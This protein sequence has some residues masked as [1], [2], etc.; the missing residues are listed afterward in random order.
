MLL[1]VVFHRPLLQAIG[2]RAAIHFAA[3]EN[4]KLDCRVEGTIFSGV[5]VRN[6]HA[7]ATGPSAVQAA[8]VE[9]VRVDFS[10]WTLLRSG[11][12]SFLK[13]VEVRNATIVV[14]PKKAPPQIDELEKDQKFTIPAFFPD[15]L[16][17][18]DINLRVISTPRDLLVEHLTLELNPAGPGELRIAKVQIPNGRAWSDIAA[19]TSYENRNLFLRDLVLDEKTKI[20]LVNLDA[21]RAGANALGL[22]FEGMITGA[23]VSGAI[24]LAEKAAAMNAGVDFVAEDMS[25]EALT[26][27]IDPPD[28]EGAD[29]DGPEIELSAK[30]SLVAGDVRRLAIKASGQLERPKSWS[31]S[32]VGR[33]DNLA[34]GGVAFDS[35]AIDISAANGIAAINAVELKQGPSN[36]SLRGTAELPETID[37]FG[38]NPAMIELRGLAPDLGAITAGMAQP[39][40]GSAEVNGRV[41]IKEATVF[42]D[43]NL[44]AGPIDF[45][46]GAVQRAI[47]KIRASKKMP[48][49]D[50]ERPY[51]EGLS[52]E[53]GFDVTDV[54]ASGFAVDAIAGEVRTNGQN[55]SV[56]QLTANRGD[57][58]LTLRGQY[59]LPTDFSQ[60]RLQPGAVEVSLVAPQLGDYWEGESPDRVTGGLQLWA[61][62]DFR[63]G[64]G[65]GSFTVHGSNLRARKLIIPELSA[66]GTTADNVV[67]LNDL[68]ARLN[69]RDYISANGTAGV[70]APYQYGGRLALSVADLGTFEPLLSA[71]G[72]KT[73]LAGTLV[74]NWEGNGA[75]STFKNT[76]NLN[77][78][79]EKGHYANLDK[80][81]AR[82]EANYSPEELNVPIIYAST[83]KLM[84]Q[85]IMQAKGSKLEMTKI[86]V[87]QG[88]AKYADGYVS[89][90]FV[91]GNL[92]S[93]RPLFAREG[94]VLVNFQTENLE[95]DKL[96]KD[97]GAEI[98]VAGLVNLKLD[99]QGTLE[100]LR[101]A[102]DLQLTGL[103]SEKLEDFTPATFGISAR[104]ENDE[105]VVNG[106]L[107]QARIEPVQITANL[108]FDVAKMIENKELDEQTPVRAKLQMPRSSVNFVRQFVPALQRIDGTAA[109]DVNVGGTIANP[110]L[111]GSADMAINA[112]RFS[113]ATLPALTNFTA[114]LAFDG[115]SLN[116]RQFHGELAGGPFTLT[117][118]IRFPKLTEPNF[119]LQLRADAVLVAR[120]DDL[121]ARVD[122]DIRVDGPLAGASVTGNIAITNSQFLKN[123]D[124]IPIGLPG[125]PAP[126]PRPPSDTPEL[127]FPNPPLRDWKF[128]VSIKTKDPFLI[129]GNLAHGGALVDMKLSGTGLEPR[130]DGSIRLQNVEATL[131]FSRLEIAQGFVY[132]N[133]DDPLN[134][135]L[136]LQ[137]TSLIK[138]YTIRVYIYGTA[139]KPEAVFTSEPPLPQ[140]EII[141][142]LATGT[143]REELMGGG[144][145]LA[146]RA[147]MLLGQQ[148]YYKIF[149]KG[150]RAST[151]SVFDR[152]QVDVG[153]V[154]PRTGQQTA[155]ARYRVTDKVLVVGDI[156]VQGDFRGT[157]KYLIRFR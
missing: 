30:E 94:Q 2:R 104:I 153:N 62:F 85:A 78:T 68:T 67:Y 93:D 21:S 56:Q 148:L 154:D 92:G 49:A 45:G 128:D 149:K 112:A 110:V 13:N 57:N 89:V 39:I 133:P 138:D 25:L 72:K 145:V 91:W 74:I 101:A 15:R 106:K 10:I 130:I 152:L 34:A 17:L 65:D 36:I 42:A 135:G 5:I 87:I 136:D 66:S 95:I 4:L 23:K 125:R 143:T 103:R 109:L 105:L 117:G 73:E 79:L 40:N 151:N 114:Q 81:E 64:L 32:V 122:A 97:F 20:A 100:D 115:D 139:E 155:T 82:V 75:V 111:S 22:K 28:M 60:A 55:V 38:R 11:L 118:Q 1:L 52:S 27:Y 131:P 7:I 80:L 107:E 58:R 99:A 24:S 121:T 33:I 29:V 76:G 144:N 8:D 113:N 44:A 147:L 88:E 116:F 16:L 84:F 137:G 6:V 14:D 150:Q 120:N 126:G 142:L 69:E 127:S 48:P 9:L 51:F 63:G 47:V 70:K 83:D 12:S 26:R 96:T 54:R 132:F 129:R 146:G 134:P 90:P 46:K 35:A 19:T 50:Q 102:L 61:Q 43:L 86:Q 41:T 108:P 156:G 3:K 18:S 53:I 59:L 77:L 141:S 98:P 71:A 31:G 37:G 123:I 140:E 119:D 157:V 124:L